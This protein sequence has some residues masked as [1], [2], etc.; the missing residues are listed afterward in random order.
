LKQSRFAELTKEEKNCRTVRRRPDLQN[1]EEE[2][3]ID[4]SL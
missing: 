3:R 2:V 1:R 4:L